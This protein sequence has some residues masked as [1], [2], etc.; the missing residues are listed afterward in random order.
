M[1]SSYMLMKAKSK[2][3]VPMVHKVFT[4]HAAG[5]EHIFL[6]TVVI[7]IISLYRYL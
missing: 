2:L 7:M 3:S 1:I 6:S 5:T 4:M